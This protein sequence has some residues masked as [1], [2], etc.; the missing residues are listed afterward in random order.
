MK[1]IICLIL[2]LV[3][4]LLS[5]GCNQQEP[6]SPTETSAVEKVVPPTYKVTAQEKQERT[7]SRLYTHSTCDYFEEFLKN[8]THIVKAKFL[9]AIEIKD[10]N[11]FNFEILDVIKGELS[12]ETISVIY[13]PSQYDGCVGNIDGVEFFSTYTVGYEAGKDYLLLLKRVSTAYLDKDVLYFIDQG[14]LVIPLD[15]AGAPDISSAQMYHIDLVRCIKDE[16]LKAAISEGKFLEKILELTEKNPIV[17]NSYGEL[18][19]ETNATSIISS[20]ENVF[21]IE[22]K[23]QNTKYAGHT[24][25]RFF[26]ANYIFDVVETSKGSAKKLN[27]NI[28]LPID[29]VEVGKKYLVA[30]DSNGWLVG[31]NAIFPYTE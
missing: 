8:T 23:S 21:I 1:K 22:L 4:L 5:V 31:R 3:I 10:Q 13:T 26:E 12:D 19:D 2:A 9:E 18:L 11:V 27:G 17:F 6:S 29:K 14:S 25:V 30:L 24:D 28:T 15:E 20:A 7:L 16:S